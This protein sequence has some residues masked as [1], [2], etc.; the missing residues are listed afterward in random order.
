MRRAITISLMLLCS[1]AGQP[2]ATDW[3]APQPEDRPFVRWWWLGSAVDE[4][5]ITWNLEQFAEKGLGGV[6]ITPIYGVQGNEAEDIEYLSPRWMEILG[7][8]L[9]E[10]DRLGLQ[11]DMSNCTGW[12]FGG[13]QVTTAESACKLLVER[14]LLHGGERMEEKIIPQDPRQRAFAMPQRVMAFG[15]G[16]RIDITG[17]VDADTVLRWQAQQGCDMEIYA[18]FCGRT[19]QKVKRAAPGGEGLVM[20]HYDIRALHSYLDRF[21]E[22]F[23]QSGAGMPDTFFNDSFEVYG[24]DWDGRLLEEFSRMHGY[25]LEEYLP[26]FLSDDGGEMSARIVSDYRQT[27]FEMLLNNFTIPWT[28]W[29]HSHGARTRNQAHG[30]PGNIIDLYAA[31]DIP[32]CESF[33]Q[34]PFDIESLNHEGPSRPNDSDR[35]VLKFASS[36]AHLTGKRRTSAEALTWLTE[37]FHTTLAL[38]KPELDRMFCAGVNHVYFHGAPYSPPGAEFPGRMF[39]ASINM[40]PTNTIWRDAEAL[41]GYITRCQSFLAAGE[42]DNDF[43]IYLPIDDIRHEYRDK[44]FLMFDIHKMPQTMPRFR[45]AVDSVLGAGYDCDYI[46]D[47]YIQSLKVDN[48][49]MLRSQGG[50]RYKALILP[51][52]RLWPAETA[53]RIVSLAREGA[54]VVFVGSVPKDVPGFGELDLRRAELGEILSSLPELTMAEQPEQRAFGRGRIITGLSYGSALQATGAVPEPYAAGGGEMIRRRNEAG[55]H[56]YFLAALGSQGIDGYV[57]LA[58]SAAAVEIFDPMTGERSMARTRD[59][60]DGTTAVRLQMPSGGSLLLKCFPKAPHNMPAMQRYYLEERAGEIVPARGWRLQFTECQ[61]QMPQQTYD[62]DSL[63]EWT[64]LPIEGADIAAGTARYTVDVEIEEPSS[65]DEWLLC[66]GDVRESAEVRI[67]GRSAGKAW[68]V[69]F[70]LR[71]GR[72]LQS[73]RNTIE[74]DVT[75]LQ[76]NRI[77]DM[78]R[79]GVKWRI[80]KDANIASVTGAADFSFGDWPT[81]PCGLASQVRLVPLKTVNE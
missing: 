40:S 81:V 68:A 60:G 13:P 80:F 75:G 19:L 8:T 67:N 54:T 38:C 78:E 1:C 66:L 24:A 17:C 11:I 39:Y 55:G 56:N 9:A 74:I 12:P 61:P 36:A 22:A 32:E 50:A 21:D 53:R 73:G 52:C 27:L 62:I 4:A 23:A 14:R 41:F 48:D 46:S 29:A 57:T 28:E 26:E 77:A 51:G 79:R 3:Y 34:T 71:V 44:R 63:I 58:T 47:R 64:R 43:L 33:G 59:N 35:A 16:E 6:E 76:A 5:G 70:Q 65:A 10:A 31:V 7:H 20:N 37:H 2:D 69:P 72:L 49:G 18:I 42:P 45:Q 30:S 15:G 25:R